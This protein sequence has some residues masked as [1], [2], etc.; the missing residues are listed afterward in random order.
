M[1]VQRERR[2]IAEN[3]MERFPRAR[4]IFNCALGPVPETLIARLGPRKALRMARGLRPAVDLVVI[5]DRRLIL[6]EGKIL[7]WLDGIAKLPVYKG[8]VPKTEELGEYRGYDI[9]MRLYS[10]WTS[11]AI[12]EA[13]RGVGVIVDV[14]HQPWIDDYLA[15]LGKYWTGEYI[16]AREE[17]KRMREIFGL[18]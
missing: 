9:E 16:A 18:E 15:E 17:K 3:A 6:V 1:G 2:L 8:L 5:K 7:R 14:F 13:A 4:L 11:E 10:P 12:E